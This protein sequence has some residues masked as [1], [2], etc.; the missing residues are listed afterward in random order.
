LR[1]VASMPPSW[2]KRRLALVGASANGLPAA[3]YRGACDVMYESGS[4]RA[5]AWGPRWVQARGVA[6]GAPGGAR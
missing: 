1:L 4:A 3:P 5:A 6:Q 2:P